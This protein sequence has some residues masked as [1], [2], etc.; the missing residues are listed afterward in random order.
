MA[1]VSEA[2][3]RLV[4]SLARDGLPP[5]ARPGEVS[6]L[7]DLLPGQALE[8]L[9]DDARLLIVPLGRLWAL[10]WP[11]VPAGGAFLGERFTLA[12]APSLTLAD[13]V[14]SREMPR[15]R[16]VGQWRSTQIKHH[17]LVAFADDKR[18]ALEGFSSADVTLAASSHPQ[19]RPGMT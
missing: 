4:S 5:K 15:P 12:V 17:E 19:R 18:V 3:Q 2:V 6:A 10:P 9:A 11:A 1:E 16:T 13:H 7:A 14:R 8:G